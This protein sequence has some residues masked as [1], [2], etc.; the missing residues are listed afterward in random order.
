LLTFLILLPA[1]WYASQDPERFCFQVGEQVVKVNHLKHTVTTNKNQEIPYDI[2]VIATGSTATLP[3][4]MPMERVQRTRGVFVYRN[5]ADLDS[6]M[7][8][9]DRD[10]VR[11]GRAAIVGGGLLGLEAAKAVHD[12]YVIF[13]LHLHSPQLN[14]RH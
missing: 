12:L 2:C 1:A 3:P 14:H 5:I 13:P 9:A 8:Y 10:G 7:A 11:G 4:F 6:I